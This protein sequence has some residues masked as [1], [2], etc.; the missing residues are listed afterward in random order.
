MLPGDVSCSIGY[1]FVK[2]RCRKCGIG[3]KNNDLDV[4]EATLDGAQ[5]WKRTSNAGCHGLVRETLTIV[6]EMKVWNGGKMLDEPLRVECAF[7]VF[8]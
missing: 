8:E 6:V 2:R 1:G 3:G 4:V 5:R 7:S